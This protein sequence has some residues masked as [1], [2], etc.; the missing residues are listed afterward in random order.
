MKLTLTF[1]VAF[2]FAIASPTQA[3]L[4]ETWEPLLSPEFSEAVD[5][6]IDWK[7]G[8]RADYVVSA[9]IFGKGTMTKEVTSEENGAIWVKQTLTV[10]GHN[11]TID[12]LYR[13]SDGAILRVVRNGQDQNP[14]D[15]KIEVISSEETPITVPAGT[16]KT[17]HIVGKTK[18]LKKIELWLNP[19]ETALDGTVKLVM[20][21]TMY[22]INSELKSFRKSN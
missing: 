7:I 8:D 12:K 1:A 5:G 15:S 2:A 22:T 18:K 17:T 16:F 11:E 21:S 19:A 9:G 10:P 13:K 6:S 4:S 3:S 14:E 20:V